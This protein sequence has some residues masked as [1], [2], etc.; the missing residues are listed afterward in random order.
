MVNL[1]SSEVLQAMA[2][3]HPVRS[4]MLPVRG[5]GG[6]GAAALLQACAASHLSQLHTLALGYNSEEDDA[7]THLGTVIGVLLGLWKEGQ[8]GAL[9]TV[10]LEVPYYRALCVWKGLL[11]PLIEAGIRVALLPVKP[12]QHVGTGGFEDVVVAVQQLRRAMPDPDLLQLAWRDE[13]HGC[14]GHM[15]A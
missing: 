3:D 5:M 1:D 11:P 8:L 12:P 9:D 10:I 6:E 4:L 15:A 2:P 13:P 14:H 7:L